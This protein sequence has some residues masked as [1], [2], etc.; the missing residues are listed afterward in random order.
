MREDLGDD[1]ITGE[2]VEDGQLP[3]MEKFQK[4]VTDLEVVIGDEMEISV[5]GMYSWAI[6]PSS[7]P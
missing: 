2:F 6:F 1:T 3:M 7:F 5:Q 4:H